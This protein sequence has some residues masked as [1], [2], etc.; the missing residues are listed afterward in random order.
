DVGLRARLR[1]R[2][3]QH[4]SQRVGDL[5]LHFLFRL[6]VDLRADQF[7]RET[8]VQSALAD[9]E[10]ELIVVDD[11]VEVRA[12]RGLVAGDR[13]AR[14]LRRS[15]RVRMPSVLPLRSMI[16]SPRS[17]RLTYPFSSSPSL[18]L[19]SLKTF[20]R[21]ASRTFCRAP[22]WPTGQRCGRSH[23]PAG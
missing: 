15:E 1:H 13:H 16:M 6:D 23:R 3:L 12:M 4:C 5:A 9:G 21:S 19:N 8:D 20:S 18:S 14:D 7:R 11:D 2:F 22:A 10:R 17:K